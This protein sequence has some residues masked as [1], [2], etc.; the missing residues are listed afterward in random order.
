MLN[1]AYK[2]I[3][4]KSSVKISMTNFEKLN[5]ILPKSTFFELLILIILFNLCID[6]ELIIKFKI[7]QNK[8]FY[9][10]ISITPS[11]VTKPPFKTFL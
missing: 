3:K 11:F 8:I 5:K 4:K 1:I 2:L 10:P 9:S 6:E 7:I